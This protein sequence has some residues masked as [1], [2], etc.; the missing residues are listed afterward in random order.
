MNTSW[1]HQL[2]EIN[3]GNNMVALI[4]YKQVKFN[5]LKEINNALV[6]QLVEQ[7]ICNQLNPQDKLTILTFFLKSINKV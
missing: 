3:L 1:Q 5:F 4:V 2:I 6:A 7:L